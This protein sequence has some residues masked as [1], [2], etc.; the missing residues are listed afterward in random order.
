MVSSDSDSDVEVPQIKAKPKRKKKLIDY[1][2]EKQAAAIAEAKKQEDEENDKIDVAFPV[3]NPLN[4]I[5][6]KDI[7]KQKFRKLQGNKKKEDKIARKQRKL[8][9]GPKTTGHTIESL[10]EKD[11]TAIENNENS[12]NEEL[13]AELENDKFSG[14]YSKI[15][16]PKVL[17]TFSD[18]PHRKTRNFG[19]ELAKIIPNSVALTRKNASIKKICKSAIKEECTDVLIINENRKEPNGL[20][21]IHLPDGPTAHFKLSN[22]KSTKELKKNIDNISEHRP[23]VILTNFT[24]RL[25]LTIGRMLGAIFHFDPEFNGRRAVTFHNQRDYIFFRHHIYQFTKDGKRPKLKEL[26]PRF[27]LKLRSLQPGLFDTICGDY[28]WMNTDKRRLMESRRRFF[29]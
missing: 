6:N 16:A 25:G 3:I 29:L 28:E 7:R 26:G 11:Q 18:L 9:G 17:I 10:R 23:E 24:T 14:F 27:T 15:Y 21:I 12:E 13:Q 5:K 2:S 4:F 20:L 19:N 22:V 8:E 1:L